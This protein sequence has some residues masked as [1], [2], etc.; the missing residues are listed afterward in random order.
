MMS[1]SCDCSNNSEVTTESMDRNGLYQNHHNRV[2]NHLF[3]LQ[4]LYCWCYKNISFHASKHCGD[5]GLIA[6]W[7]RDK[8]DLTHIC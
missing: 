6:D 4:I 7:W 3:M 8:I 2:K 5:Y 1:H